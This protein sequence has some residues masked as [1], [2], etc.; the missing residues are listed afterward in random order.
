MVDM[1]STEL[2]LSTQGVETSSFDKPTARKN[3]LK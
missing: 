3:K 2:L 1:V